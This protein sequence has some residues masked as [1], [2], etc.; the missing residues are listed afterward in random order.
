MP[1]PVAISSYYNIV[2][3]IAI[4]TCCC[5]QRSNHYWYVKHHCNNAFCFCHCNYLEALQTHTYLCFTFSVYYIIICTTCAQQGK[6]KVNALY[7]HYVHIN[8][9]LYSLCRWRERIYLAYR[10][11][12]IIGSACTCMQYIICS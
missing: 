10:V 7:P 6:S 1:C 8:Y 2:V 12:Y 9:D 3:A 11:N 4:L 5:C